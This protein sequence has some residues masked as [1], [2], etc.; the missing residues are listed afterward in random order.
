MP[1]VVG[2]ALVK[3]SLLFLGIPL[4]DWKFRVLFRLI[5]AKDGSRLL[6]NYNHVAV[7]VDPSKT[8]P[9]NARRAKKYL[10]KYF[11][12]S[13]ISIYWGAAADFLRD[14]DSHLKLA[15]AEASHA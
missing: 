13:N 6:R 10:E 15:A 5:L 4:D 8:T 7:Q 2:D 12:T 1:K 11:G 3:G 14:L 9:A